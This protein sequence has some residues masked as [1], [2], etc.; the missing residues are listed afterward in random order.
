MFS[1]PIPDIAKTVFLLIVLIVVILLKM[2]P[3]GGVPLI[4][5]IIGF[6]IVYY[7]LIWLVTWRSRQRGS[8]AAKALIQEIQRLETDGADVLL[9]EYSTRTT[10]QDAIVRSGC[11]AYKGDGTNAERH[12]RQAITLLEESGVHMQKD[13]D[14]RIIY[15]LS[16]I[17]LYDARL[18]QGQFTEAAE[19]LRPYS[20]GSPAPTMLVVLVIWAL[21][22]AGEYENARAMLSYVR[23]T[24][25]A[26]LF[27]PASPSRYALIVTYMRHKLLASNTEDIL[28]YRDA[29]PKWKDDM[30]RNAHNPYGARLREVLDDLRAVFDAP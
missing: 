17:G 19:G 16:Q 11:F 21:Y 1:R 18:L 5:L 15:E 3:A 20:D 7:L 10:A 24:T 12:A 4:L 25:Q 6:T 26:A 13:R 14:S 29:F 22:L 28:L 9:A 2:S 30:D 8:G 27:S 23:I